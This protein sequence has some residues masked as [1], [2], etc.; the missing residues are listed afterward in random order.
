M[1]FHL[2]GLISFLKAI[3]VWINEKCFLKRR[4]YFGLKTLKYD[5]KQLKLLFTEH[6]LSHAASAFYL[7]L[8]KIQLSLTIDGVGEW[9][10]ASIGIEMVKNNFLSNMKI[11]PILLVYCIVHFIIW[12]L[13]STLVNINSLSLGFLW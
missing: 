2:K 5:K 9:C 13:Q 1:L 3:P 8:M 12:G 11:S 7:L 6:H 4:F 10:T